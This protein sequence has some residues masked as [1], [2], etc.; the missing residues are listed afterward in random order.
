METTL[1]EIEFNDGRK[2]RVFCANKTQ[3]LKNLLQ[4]QELKSKGL[5]KSILHITSGI[6]TQK[7]FNEIINSIYSN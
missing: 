3:K 1:F 5:V 6:H 4:Y 7:Q 2:F